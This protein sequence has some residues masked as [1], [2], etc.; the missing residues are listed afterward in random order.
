MAEA[1]SVANRGRSFLFL[2]AIA[3]VLGGYVWFVEMK[4]DPNASTDAPR[5]KLFAV[6][7]AQ[8]QEIRL[9]NE[10]GEQSTLRRAAEGRWSLVEVPGAQV[11]ET[12]A[13][14]IATGLASLEASRVVDEQPPSLAEYGLDTPRVT[15]SFTDAAGK[16]HTLLMG[17]KTPAGGDVYAKLADAPRVVLIGAWHEETFNRSRFDL[18]D[19]TVMTF[20]RD[21]A[22]GITLTSDNRVMTLARRSGAWTMTSPSEAP[23]DDAAVDAL[24]GRLASEKMLSIVDDPAAVDTGLAKPSAS[25]A[26][27]AGPTRAV[28]EL[29]GPA[30]EGRVYARGSSRD[31]VFTVDASLLD[32]LRKSPDEFLKKDQ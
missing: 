32:E 24:L 3:A 6:E 31:L 21:A 9:T 20:A 15:A 16:Q 11:D 4:R 22:G 13:G 2:L 14:S 27:T 5:E 17:S 25:V 10:A 1:L 26:I 19:K 8:I 28:L 29:G 7:P 30:G 23:A 18:R 12:E